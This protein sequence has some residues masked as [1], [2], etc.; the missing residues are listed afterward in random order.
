MKLWYQHISWRQ[1]S[2]ISILPLFQLS[3]DKITC[4]TLIKI[5]RYLRLHKKK[6]L[7]LNVKV[8]KITVK[9]SCLAKAYYTKLQ[10]CFARNLLHLAGSYTRNQL[11]FFLISSNHE[12]MCYWSSS[13]WSAEVEATPLKNN[14]IWIENAFTSRTKTSTSKPG[15]LAA[16]VV[17]LQ[18]TMNCSVKSICLPFAQCDHVIF[19]TL[20][21]H[22]CPN[23]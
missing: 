18:W 3:Q 2:N 14:V 8:E 7:I 20:G 6:M 5:N 23:N 13:S 21:T 10:A 15:V 17:A 9:P 19:G 1:P 4:G 11:L 22:N 12:E 16:H